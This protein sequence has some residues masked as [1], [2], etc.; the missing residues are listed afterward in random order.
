MKGWWRVDERAAVTDSGGWDRL[1]N[2]VPHPLGFGSS[3]GAAVDFVF[4]STSCA[5]A[6]AA[7]RPL[8]RVNQGAQGCIDGLLVREVFG[9]IR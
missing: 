1:L 2:W 8:T 3:K 4:S 9:D 5:A 6:G 7:A